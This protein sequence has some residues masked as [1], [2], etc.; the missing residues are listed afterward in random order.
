MTSSITSLVTSKWC[1]NDINVTS[2]WCQ[3]QVKFWSNNWWRQFFPLTFD[4]KIDVKIDENFDIK[5]TSTRQQNDDKMT[6]K[7]STRHT[8]VLVIGS[9]PDGLNQWRSSAKRWCSVFT[10]LSLIASLMAWTSVWVSSSSKST[11]TARFWLASR[12]MFGL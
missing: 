10:Y 6:S 2:N 9:F 3:F 8:R 12:R 11:Y 4:V 7:T 5:L 1:W